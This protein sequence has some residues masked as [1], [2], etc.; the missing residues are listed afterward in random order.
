MESRDDS[1]MCRAVGTGHTIWPET[2]CGEIRTLSCHEGNPNELMM[3]EC[4]AHGQWKD[5]IDKNCTCS[6]DSYYGTQWPQTAA[7]ATARMSCSNDPTVSRER[8]CFENG[9]WSN[10]VTG[11]C[12]CKEEDY[13]N[14]HWYDRKLDIHVMMGVLVLDIVVC[15]MWMEH[16]IKLLWANVLVLLF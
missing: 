1:C 2:R 10:I 11:G 8:E 16:G 3:R 6:E 14:V 15:V 5:Y 4:D 9:E 13:G 12:M 7:G